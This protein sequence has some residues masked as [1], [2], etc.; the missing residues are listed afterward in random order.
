MTV[1]Y[2]SSVA[3]QIPYN[4]LF[5]TVHSMTTQLLKFYSTQLRYERK[6]D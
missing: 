3:F 2:K 1:D 4:K 5:A 6:T